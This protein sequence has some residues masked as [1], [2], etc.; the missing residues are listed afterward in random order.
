MKR[1]IWLQL[2]A[3]L[4]VG[5]ERSSQTPGTTLR[6]GPF[7]VVVPPEWASTAILEKRPINPAYSAGE[8]A[9]FQEDPAHQLKPGYGNRP[10]HWAI[11]F[12]A[13]ALQGTTFDAAEAGDNH[14]APQIL[15]HKADEWDVVFTDGSHE[16]QT[17]SETLARLRAELVAAKE[18]HSAPRSPAFVDGSMDFPSLQKPLTFVG[19]WG[20]RLVCQWGWEPDLIRRGRLHY[21]FIGLSD[22]GSCQI[23]ATFPLD[24]ADLPDDS[25][26][27]EHL[28][29]S[30]SRYEDL[31][32]GWETYSEEA[33]KWIEQNADGFSPGLE[34]LDEIIES[35][36]AK[37]WE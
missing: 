25:V 22:E 27:A 6:A 24:H 8:W 35:L 34:T 3:A 1:R 16:N 36:Q 32:R 10:Q 4:L 11:I 19:G 20:V 26:Q 5:C 17:R 15:I 12:P 30:V 7:S 29:R 2:S 37:S 31:A 21:L 23:I 13:A 9:A 28:G 33:V 14:E 18:N